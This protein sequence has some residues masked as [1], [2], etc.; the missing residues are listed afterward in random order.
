MDALEG[1]LGCAAAGG[2][3]GCGAHAQASSSVS[4]PASSSPWQRDRQHGRRRTRR[5]GSS[6][7]ACAC[8]GRARLRAAPCLPGPSPARRSRGRSARSRR[9]GSPRS[10][11][12][13]LPGEQPPLLALAPPVEQVGNGQQ[14]LVADAAEQVTRTG[15]DN[16]DGLE[17]AEKA[18]GRGAEEGQV[19]REGLGLLAG[20]RRAVGVDL[21]GLGRRLS[22]A[23]RSRTLQ[24][25][26]GRWTS[27]RNP[28]ASQ[29]AWG[30]WPV[31]PCG[32][33]W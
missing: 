27:G 6:P 26:S 20:E 15:N 2:L 28:P 29:R 16:D 21:A 1:G 11:R 31:S 5:G 12:R 24:R 22:D 3:G 19:D 9:A 10:Q 25:Q 18:L 30:G 14:E 23:D 4:S 13:V 32:R 8:P 17:G 7:V 33:W